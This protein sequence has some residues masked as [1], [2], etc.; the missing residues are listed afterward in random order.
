MVKLFPTERN[1]DTLIVY[2]SVVPH[3]FPP[4]HRINFVRELSKYVNVIFVDLPSN[5]RFAPLSKLIKFYVPLIK[6]FFRF[7]YS[8][9]WEFFRFRRFHFSTLYLYLL[10]QKYYFKKRIVLFT[11]SGY[12]DPIYRYIPYNRSIF[13]CPDIHEREFEGNKAWI[14]KF[15][16]VFAN[17]NLVYKCVKKYNNNVKMLPSGYRSDSRLDF[18]EIKIPN[19]VLF[20]GGISQ[21]IDYD[22]LNGV[23]RALPEVHFYFMGEVYLK[24]YYSEPEDSFRLKKWRSILSYPNVHY[25]SNFSEEALQSFLPFFKVG[26][27]PYTT[28]DLFNNYCNPIKLYDYL[29]YGMSV[30]S[31]PLPNVI[32]FQDNFPIYTANTGDEFV[33]MLRVALRK[34]DKDTLKYKSKIA[35]LLKKQS[36]EKKTSQVLREI[37][38]LFKE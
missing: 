25:L 26:I 18:S 33:S 13:D 15:D 17:T 36:V 5:F 19:S 6:T 8:F 1:S 14:E 29:A 32:S 7:D 20:L 22:L 21:R 9:V 30:V 10:F 28:N 3:D 12:D 4:F 23:V 24:K 2:C 11:T 34:S 35:L 27:I 31:T 16:V 38:L 37:S